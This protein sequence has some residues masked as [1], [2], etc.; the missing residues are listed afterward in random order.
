M[1]DSWALILSPCGSASTACCTRWVA[2]SIA[3]LNPHKDVPKPAVSAKDARRTIDARQVGR[4]GGLLATAKQQP[5]GVQI[6]RNL[7]DSRP[8]P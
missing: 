5:L 1:C 6:A 2:S 3:S 7:T 8:K 4:P